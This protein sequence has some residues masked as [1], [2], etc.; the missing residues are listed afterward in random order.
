MPVSSTIDKRLV[1]PLSPSRDA[2][3]FPARLPLAEARPTLSRE[4]VAFFEM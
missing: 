2:D 1:S 3:T 4:S